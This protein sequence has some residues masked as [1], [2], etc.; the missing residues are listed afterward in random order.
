MSELRLH[1]I[2][3]FGLILAGSVLLRL[4]PEPRY[5]DDPRWFWLFGGVALFAAGLGVFTAMGASAFVGLL[6]LR[7]AERAAE[8][9][10]DRRLAATAQASHASS[11]PNGHRAAPRNAR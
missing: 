10:A 3:T 4:A 2:L 9:E 6:R 1:L 7:R 5:L 8:E 11:Q